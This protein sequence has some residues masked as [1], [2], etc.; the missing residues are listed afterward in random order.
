[1][2]QVNNL[3]VLAAKQPTELALGAIGGK[4][5]KDLEKSLEDSYKILKEKWNTETKSEVVDSIV[6]LRFDD[7][8]QST[9]I[10]YI[11]NLQ[12]DHY[13]DYAN[14]IMGLVSI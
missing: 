9:Q 7:Y 8:E 11:K 14:Y 5:I 2:A 4:N 3:E 6:N 10:Q 1:M 12:G 13:D